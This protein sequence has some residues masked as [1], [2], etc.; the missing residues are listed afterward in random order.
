M[1][2]NRNPH[3][4]PAV[5]RQLWPLWT[6]IKAR[7]SVNWSHTV[8]EHTLAQ[9]VLIKISSL[10]SHL[11]LILSRGSDYR[12]LSIFILGYKYQVWAK[13]TWNVIRSVIFNLPWIRH[14]FDTRCHPW[15]SKAKCALKKREKK[16]CVTGILSI[17]LGNTQKRVLNVGQSVIQCW[18]AGFKRQRWRRKIWVWK[19]A[20]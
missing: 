6:E 8:Y 16:D 10:S 12:K 15:L 4:D 11:S 20:S 19:E 5:E 2:Q 18:L 1:T 17:P 3:L 9:S 7:C 14:T 13:G